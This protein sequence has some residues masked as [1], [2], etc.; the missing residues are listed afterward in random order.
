MRR[1]LE[2]LLALAFTLAACGRVG[3][4]VRSRPKPEPAPAVQ[5]AAAGTPAAQDEQ[6]DEEK[7]R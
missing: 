1:L 2:I 7:K 4:P 3:P 5:P 6:N